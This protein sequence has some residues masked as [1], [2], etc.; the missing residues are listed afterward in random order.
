MLFFLPFIVSLAGLAIATYTDLRSRI[1]SDKLTYSMLFIGIALQAVFALLLSNFRIF[2]DSAIVILATFLASYFF[3]KIGV[4]AGGD[5]KL[6]VALASLN[7]FNLFALGKF[8]KLDFALLQPVSIPLFPLTLFVFSVFA[9]L[10]YGVFLS[11]GKLGKN[12]EISKKFFSESKNS[13]ASLLAASVFV[14]G[15]NFVLSSVG[16]PQLLGF[17]GIFFL[18]I[19][20][21]KVID[22]FFKKFELS[23]TLG[24]ILAAFYFDFAGALFSI[25][26]VFSGFFIF[27]MALKL[28]FLSKK[29]M[30][31]EK[32]VSELEEGMIAAE[33]IRIA[34]DGKP[35]RMQ[36]IETKTIIKYLTD[37]K[38]TEL[39]QYL[40]PS[41]FREIVSPSK[42]RGVNAEEILELK[43]FV[44]EGKLEDKISIKESAP[45]V[46]AILIAY[47]ALNLVGDILWHLIGF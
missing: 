12:P 13:M 14:T 32:K 29:L 21:K 31:V 36:S 10:P 19:L 6:M 18:W 4:W 42:A 20:L 9:M 39:K 46:P 2:I 40:S 25:T 23:L 28:F 37:N 26:L 34:G 24:L 38:L 45:F 16:I 11:L 41:G 17:V 8:L 47:V 43:K 7:P 27:A 30:K 5:V 33:T 15:L 3:Y 44:A 22:R 35:E 1:I